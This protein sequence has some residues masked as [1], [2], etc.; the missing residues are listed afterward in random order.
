MYSIIISEPEKDEIEIIGLLDPL[1]ELVPTKIFH[2]ES[3]TRHSHI[4]ADSKIPIYH[5]AIYGCLTGSKGGCMKCIA[6]LWNC[7]PFA[8][9]AEYFSFLAINACG[10]SASQISTPKV[11]ANF[12]SQS[13]VVAFKENSFR[14]LLSPFLYGDCWYIRQ[15]FGS[16]SSYITRY[17][18]LYSQLQK[19][20]IG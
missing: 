8:I 2:F 17:I 13:K 18:W 1:S 6:S 16:I 7:C 9:S 15:I 10:R 12:A 19:Q 14:T 20:K 3:S 4:G 11:F 5:L